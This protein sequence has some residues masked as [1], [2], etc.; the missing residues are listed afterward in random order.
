MSADRDSKVIGYFAYSSAVEVV[1]TGTACVIAGSEAAMRA[2]LAE[3]DPAGAARH[4][5]RKTR[6]AEI[7]AGMERGASYALDEEAY[8]RFLPLEQDAGVPAVQVDF[9]AARERGDRFIT[10]QPYGA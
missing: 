4:T 2:F 8:R 10:L 3:L 7:L 9:A 5:I 1:C 6:F